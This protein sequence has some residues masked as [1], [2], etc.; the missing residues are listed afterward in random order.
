MTGSIAT[1]NVET[2]EKTSVIDSS[3]CAH[4][5]S[6]PV[7]Q[8]DHERGPSG[9]DK[10]ETLISV[11]ADGRISKWF[12]WKGLDCIDLMKLKRTRNEKAKKQRK[13]GRARHDITPGAGDLFRLPFDGERVYTLEDIIGSTLASQL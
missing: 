4:K 3:D 9:E 5:H 7:W 11:S 13:R 12:L 6:S 2:R 1:Y 8:V 10:G